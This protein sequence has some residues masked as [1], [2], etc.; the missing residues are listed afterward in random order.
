MASKKM[1]SDDFYALPRKGM[2]R[3]KW[4]QEQGL[5]DQAIEQIFEHNILVYGDRDDLGTCWLWNGTVRAQD[6]LPI[7]TRAGIYMHTRPLLFFWKYGH[8]AKQTY[9]T[10]KCGNCDCVNPRHYY[11]EQLGESRQVISLFNEETD[12]ILTKYLQDPISN[13][14]EAPEYLTYDSILES[15]VLLDIEY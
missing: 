15:D 9:I 3:P 4:L 7:A 1:Y 12:D 2:S 14:T 11:H 13:E 8:E 10:T 6:N 5:L